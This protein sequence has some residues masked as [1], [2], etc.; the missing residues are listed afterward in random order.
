[1]HAH[2]HAAVSRTH[3]NRKQSGCFI[4]KEKQA[5]FQLVY[6]RIET[7]LFYHLTMWINLIEVSIRMYCCMLLS[8]SDMKMHLK[9][10]S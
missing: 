6:K 9:S 5:G 3:V 10:L 4:P 1:M 8:I 7:V 2:T